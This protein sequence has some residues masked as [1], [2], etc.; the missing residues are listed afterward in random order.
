MYLYIARSTECVQLEK[1]NAL[2]VYLIDI[3]IYR[4]FIYGMLADTPIF[5][6]VEVFTN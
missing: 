6:H 3:N 1:G 2:A 4:Y 5:Y